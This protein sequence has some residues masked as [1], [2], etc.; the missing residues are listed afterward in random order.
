VQT[1]PL[2]IFCDRIRRRIGT[3]L[4][5]V[6]ETYEVNQETLR[7]RPQ[8]NFQ[9]VSAPSVHCERHRPVPRRSSPLRI[10][11]F[12]AAIWLATLGWFAPVAMTQTVKPTPVV[13]VAPPLSTSVSLS[14]APPSAVEVLPPAAADP[15]ITAPLKVEPAGDGQPPTPTEHCANAAAGSELWLL[16]TRRLPLG[17]DCCS[18]AFEPRVMRFICGHGFTPSTLEEF[19]VDEDPN[20]P[21]IVFVHGNDTDAEYAAEAGRELY[22]QL[23]NS[24]CAS[25]IRLVIWSWPSE[26]VVKCVRKDARIKACRT[27]IEGY[28]LASFLDLLPAHTHVGLIG[29]SYGAR[30]VTGALHIQGGGIIE[31]RQIVDPKHP[32]RDPERCVLLAAAMDYDWLYPSMRH[33]RAVSQ[34][35]RMVITISRVDPVL[36][37]YPMLWGC[38]GPDALGV[39]GLVGPGRLGREAMKIA[40]VDITR[41]VHRRHSWSFFADSPEIMS[42]L[43]HELMHWPAVVAAA[44]KVPPDP[45][46]AR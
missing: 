18:P 15:Q 9:L 14:L 22:N 34:V 6:N 30:V 3:R 10:L 39:T 23:L 26:E 1:Q 17:G 19:I 24:K 13:R 40:Q 43:R 42:L 5:K 31:G 2:G 33:D 8:R 21:T 41:A 38:G 32:D 29:Y 44:H 36:N 7:S 28:F 35:E 16:S 12:L 11:P 46:S 45:I 37:F 27:N 20:R 25:P 4:Q